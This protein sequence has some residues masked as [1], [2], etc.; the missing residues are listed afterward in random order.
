MHIVGDGN[1]GNFLAIM[2]RQ[3]E[4]VRV[5]SKKYQGPKKLIL[6]T[7][8]NH[9]TTTI[10]YLNK[11]NIKNK[12]ELLIIATKTYDLYNSLNDLQ[13]Y[14][15]PNTIIILVQ[16]GLGTHAIIKDLI[17]NNPIIA[18]PLSYGVKTIAPQTLS[19]SL[20]GKIQLG[21]LA[22]K[23]LTL[24]QQQQIKNMFQ[25]T[26]LNWQWQHNIEQKIKQKF[27]INC[28]I[29]PLTV[30][31]N[32]QNGSLKNIA[33]CKYIIEKLANEI[34][35]TIPDIGWSSTELITETNNVITLTA[36]NKSS[37][38]TDYQNNK[39]TEI[40]FLNKQLSNVAKKNN[41]DIPTNSA[42]LCLL[43]TLI[44]RQNDG[45]NNYN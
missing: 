3:N 26:E 20:Q 34:S 31:Y 29:N 44:Q 8:N 5:I 1:I 28:I 7:P 45:Q 14:L 11:D 38:L 23:T 24:E 15:K 2:F 43:S 25:A 22:G 19:S 40:E 35:K 33:G 30:I 13:H 37:M 27:A 42:I 17:P 32:C 21:Q 4:L 18:A 41:I 12:P 9:I 16:N 10:Q 6:Q 39:A 36:T